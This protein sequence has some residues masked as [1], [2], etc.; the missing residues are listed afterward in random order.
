MEEKRKKL[1]KVFLNKNKQ[2][3]LSAIRDGQGV[4]DKHIRDS[5][6]IKN[7]FELHQNMK[8]C[9]VG[10]GWGFPLLILAMEY[11]EINFVGMDSVRK[12]INAIDEMLGELEVEN[13]DLIWKR[14]EEYKW[15]RFDVLT[16]RAVAYVDKLLPWT[17]HLLKK[18]GYWILYKKDDQQ[19]KLELLY[20]CKKMNLKLE[21]EHKYKLFD[22]DIDRVIYVIRKL[23]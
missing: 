16:A 18:N 23:W 15:E 21:K 3:N 22:G 11:P 20:L 9:D 7:A 14:A 17:E 13:V 6:E 12:K 4:R 19:E 1:I 10:T 5:L 2:I 8:I